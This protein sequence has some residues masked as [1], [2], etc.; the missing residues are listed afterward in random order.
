MKSPFIFETYKRGGLLNDYLWYLM[1]PDPIDPS[2]IPVVIT[3]N[4][5][6]T[7][8]VAESMSGKIEAAIIAAVMATLEENE[9]ED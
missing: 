7:V 8:E 5:A 6:P 3:T 9:D 4:S 1:A 2:M